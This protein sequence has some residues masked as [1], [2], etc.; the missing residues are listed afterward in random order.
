M[1]VARITIKKERNLLN[2]YDANDTDNTERHWSYDL[3]NGDILGFSGRKVRNVPGGWKRTLQDLSA[4]ASCRWNDL[5]LND[6]ELLAA[7]VFAGDNYPAKYIK[8]VERLLAANAF[9]NFGERDKRVCI[10]IS[11]WNADFDLL[12][13][14]DFAKFCRYLKEYDVDRNGSNLWYAINCFIKADKYKDYQKQIDKFGQDVVEECVESLDNLDNLNVLWNWLGSR[15]VTTLINIGA[16]ASC[17]G[18]SRYRQWCG[19][20][21]GWGRYFVQ[22]INWAGLMNL[23]VSKGTPIAQCATIER[24]FKEYKNRIPNDT[25]QKH[26]KAEWANLEDDDFVIIVPTTLQELKE[27]GNRMHNCIGGMWI[28]GYGNC[29]EEGRQTRG[30][31]FVRRADDP[32][33]PFIDCD[34]EL[35]TMEIVQFYGKYNNTMRDDHIWRFREKLQRHLRTFV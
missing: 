6:G 20:L 19:G 22:M 16:G 2:F 34:F 10:F 33:E 30:I 13:G 17:K 4:S 24:D 7:L 28:D 27:E 12:D 23:E 8:F 35:G 29:L 21:E 18:H 25:L 1:A 11:T 5:T 26:Q 31:V 9:E 15:E 32:A 14:I 3:N